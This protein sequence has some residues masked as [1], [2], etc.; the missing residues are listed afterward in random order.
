MYSGRRLCS[1]CNH[2][3]ATGRAAANMRGGMIPATCWWWWWCVCAD[4]SNR[5]LQSNESFCALGVAC[6]PCHGAMVCLFC[7]SKSRARH[8]P[9]GNTSERH[10]TDRSGPTSANI[11]K[12]PFLS[13][14]RAPPPDKPWID[15]KPRN[16]PP[17]YH[18]YYC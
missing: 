10:I 2:T 8:V 1:A 18:H 16:A 6:E 4:T 3:A 14:F 17:P 5:L 13:F 9:D 11:K 15:C 12:L 7:A